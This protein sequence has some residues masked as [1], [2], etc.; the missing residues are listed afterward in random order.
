MKHF[1]TWRWIGILLLFAIACW[2]VDVR[3]QKAIIHIVQEGENLFRISLRYGTTVD[4]IMA[5]NDLSNIYIQVGQELVIPVTAE[6][7]PA[8][9]PPDSQ[10]EE[11]YPARQHRA[12]DRRKR[13]RPAG[14][15]QL[16]TQGF[17]DWL[18]QV[19]GDDH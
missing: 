5:A 8:E 9:T 10:L 13:P 4:A 15:F 1:C 18:N 17:R 2:P 16:P 3:A 6:D 12:G 11:D 19:A 7:V 14:D